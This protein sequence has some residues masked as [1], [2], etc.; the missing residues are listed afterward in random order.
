MIT[1]ST[2]DLI[3]AVREV[4][5]CYTE[6]LSQGDGDELSAAS[7]AQLHD[8]IVNELRQSPTIAIANF[9]QLFDIAQD[10]V[11]HVLN[12]PPIKRVIKRLFAE[13]SPKDLPDQTPAIECAVIF[14][15]GLSIQG[16]LSERPDG[17]LRMLSPIASAPGQP[18]MMAE[19]FFEYE[20]IVLVGVRRQVNVD[21]PRIIR[22]S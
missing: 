10:A 1:T 4:G 18:V 6:L 20:D 9:A 14:R 13:E 16:A 21:Q 5:R 7:R 11:M 3:A 2:E 8:T 12:E 22:A 15:S 19:Q 17:G